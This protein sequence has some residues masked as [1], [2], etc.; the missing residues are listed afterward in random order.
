MTLVIDAHAHIGKFTRWPLAS[1]D[2]DELVRILENEGISYALVSSALSLGYDCTAGNEEVLQAA[3][4]HKQVIPLLVVNPWH[5]EEAVEAL[6]RA[7]EQGFVGAK[8]HP[9]MH[10]FI[11]SSKLAQT[12]L[13]E[14]QRLKLPVLS[15]AEEADPRC[16][17]EQF[18]DVLAKFPDLV[19]IAGH[20][21]I[22][23]SHYIVEVGMDYPNLYVDISVN[24]ES[25]KLE[26]T[27]EGLGPDRVMFG[28][29]VP[30]HH[31]A[32]ILKRLQLIGLP[33]ED[34]RKILSQTAIRVFSLDLS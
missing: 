16:G 13:A 3:R 14:C 5:K 30:L 33:E 9:L 2:G 15:H 21:G 28:S 26:R 12:I 19:L 20:G 17:A 29:D 1:A 7:R 11:L 8:I 6:A 32:V 22:F 31:P 27:I 24:Y 4:R 18:A 34:E 23:S 25:G 10:D